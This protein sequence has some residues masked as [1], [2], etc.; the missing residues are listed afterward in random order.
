M[1]W[2]FLIAWAAVML[3]T[4]GC[5]S[6]QQSTPRQIALDQCTNC[7]VAVSPTSQEMAFDA[8]GRIWILPAEG[9]KARAIT[10]IFGNARQPSWHPDG[11]KLTFQAYWEGNWHIYTLDRDGHNLEQLTDGIYDHREPH[12]SPDGRTI[13]FS[14]DRAGSY[15]LWIYDMEGGTVSPLT[16]KPHN[17]YAPA[18][19]P[20]GE[21]VVFVSDDPNAPGLYRMHVEERQMQLIH[22]SPDP[23]FGP[24]WSPDQRSILFNQLTDSASVLMAL[25]IEDKQAKPVNSLDDVFPFRANWIDDSIIAFTG[26]GLIHQQDLQQETAHAISFQ[27]SADLE[28]PQ[29]PF[30]SRNHDPEADLPIKGLAQPALSP[31]GQ[32]VAVVMLG[33]IWTI[34]LD[35]TCTQVT[36]DHHMELSPIWSP[37]GTSLAYLGDRSGA[38]ALYIQALDGSEPKMLHPTVGLVSGIAWSPSGDKIALASNFG[39][40]LGRISCYDLSSESMSAISPMLQSSIG[41]P[42]WTGDGRAVAVST[43]T[44]YSSR[45]REGI[46]RALFYSLD[47]SLVDRLRGM[48][49]MSLG[50]RAKD[51]P[52]ISPNGQHIATISSGRLWL[53]TL[54]GTTVTAQPRLLYQGL[55]DSPSW[56]GAS[57]EVLF[58]ATDTLKKVHLPSGKI[59]PIVPNKTWHRQS[60]DG[61]KIVHAGTL[62]TGLD[63]LLLHDVDIVISGNRITE[64]RPHQASQDENVEY[65]DAS[66]HF[67]MPGLIDGHSHQGSYE[68]RN[69][70]LAW[71]SWGVTSTRDPASEPYDA[72]NRREARES[73]HSIGPRIFFTGSPFDG[74]RIYYPGA[75]ALSSKEQI[76]LELERA[77]R[78][79]FDMIKTYVRLSDPLQRDIISA[80]HEMGIPVSS[81]ELFPAVAMGIDGIEHVSGT[82][83]RGYSAKFSSQ[84]RAYRDV[85]SLIAKSGITFT[86]TTG[87]YI[88]YNYL[89]SL[90]DSPLN[91]PRVI[92]FANPG[93]I[94]ATRGALS[95]YR[96]HH[97]RYKERF[98]STMKMVGD[99]HR[100]GGLV[101]AGTDGPIIPYGFGLHME[102][103]SYHHAGLS[104]YEVLRTCTVNAAKLLHADHELGSIESGKLADMLIL[105]DNPLEDI[106][107]TRSMVKVIANGRV[108]ALDDL[109]KE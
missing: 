5:S 52:M 78:L 105:A 91:D 56:N 13:V 14:S 71:L 42:S 92:R 36:H 29:Y 16:D 58:M 72:L 76:L 50:V 100:K 39:P 10:D 83:R 45:F 77:R 20:S 103:E 93:M 32:K 59:T 106:R 98:E 54:E 30:K 3:G 48:E 7:A 85:T 68:G 43:L 74:N 51:G 34:E 69:L 94:G 107:N 64:V 55:A 35:G 49:D 46:N 73:G 24:S 44:P 26:N 22:D 18:W 90:D 31:D 95:A 62:F 28:R 87:I 17:T 79:D 86:P 60:P 4:L 47:G 109:L 82:S 2:S 67:V 23:L 40:R 84:N 6:S 104:N 89:L 57:D 97:G 15:D 81:H 19:S 27:Y 88:A 33:D 101:T 11:S 96:E 99:V 66:N 9:G 25:H 75:S 38:F 8:L 21:E 37:D 65:I 12:W 63:S 53:A 70:D 80:A 1:P 61:R 108:H 102:L 41:A